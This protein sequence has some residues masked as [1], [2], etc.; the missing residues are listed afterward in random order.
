[1]KTLCSGHI[2]FD[3]ELLLQFV[4]DPFLNALN[5]TKM[6]E[7]AGPDK[8]RVGFQMEVFLS[9]FCELEDRKVVNKFWSD[10][11]SSA[12][13]KLSGPVPTY[14]FARAVFKSLSGKLITLDKNCVHSIK[15][16]CEFQVCKKN[17]GKYVAI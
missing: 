3:H 8:C 7:N 9:R 15:E 10:L 4:C 17:F 1:M 16:F 2:L 11:L 6:F 12:F 14:Y 13:K 5:L